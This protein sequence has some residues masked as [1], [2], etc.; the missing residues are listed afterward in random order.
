MT[1]LPCLWMTPNWWDQSIHT[2]QGRA[3]I[4]R[5]PDRLE[6]WADRN[7]M[8]F[9]K[10]EHQVLHLGRKDPLQWHKLGAAC[11]AAEQLCGTLLGVMVQRRPT[12]SQDALAGAWPLAQ[13]MWLS[14]CTQHLWDCIYSRYVQFWSPQDKTHNDKLRCVQL[15]DTKMVR[16]WNIC[17]ARR[18]WG[19]GACST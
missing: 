12:A 2:L 19:N 15:G 4:Q 3:A 17:P 7:L 11:L 10:D 1:F 8:K 14:P 6:G 13:G 18:G 9:N 5:D 16:D